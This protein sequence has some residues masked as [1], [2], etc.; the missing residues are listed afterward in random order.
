VISLLNSKVEDHPHETAL[1]VYENG[2]WRRVSY[3]EIRHRAERLSDYLIER[4]C[5]ANERAAIL[6]DSGPEWGIAFFAIV[7]AGAIVLP[8][9][10]KLGVDELTGPAARGGAERPLHLHPLRCD[11]AGAAPPNRVAHRR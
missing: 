10:T 3:A 6:A 4:G 2:F 8:L 5:G 9:D 1:S 11:R 7:R